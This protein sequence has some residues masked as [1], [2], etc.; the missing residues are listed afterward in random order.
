MPSVAVQVPTN[1]DLDSEQVGLRI[2][3]YSGETDY[4]APDIFLHGRDYYCPMPDSPRIS[5][6]ADQS[7]FVRT[8]RLFADN[9][10]YSGG[11]W[12][13]RKAFVS[14]ERLKLFCISLI[15]YPYIKTVSSKKE[16]Y[17]HLPEPFYGGS[18]T[19]GNAWTFTDNR[20]GSDITRYEMR[21]TKI[22]NIHG[23]GPHGQNPTQTGNTWN[24]VTQ[25][26]IWTPGADSSFFLPDEAYSQYDIT[27]LFERL[28]YLVCKRSDAAYQGEF[29]RFLL[30]Q[31]EPLG[32]ALQIRGGAQWDTA[33]GYGQPGGGDQVTGV[34]ST[35]EGAPRLI[36]ENMI[37]WKW[38]DVPLAAYN[39]ESW[40]TTTWKGIKSAF[41]KIN[42][43]DFGSYTLSPFM[44]FGKETLLLRT[45]GRMQKPSIIGTPLWDVT[46]YFQHSPASDGYG[47]WNRLLNNK[48]FFQRYKTANAGSPNWYFSETFTKLFQSKD[49]W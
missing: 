16:L 4:S 38:L 27:V 5:A 6:A 45:A 12:V 13:S 34:F 29:S 43:N 49:Y 37:T 33:A 44:L 8:Y 24:P 7:Q 46:F 36:G 41:G 10:P 2:N 28:P 39:W 35:K 47:F 1:A 22:L 25:S 20:T 30:P 48:G 18:G 15:G 26:S 14:S 19:D 31:E 17:R 23:I 42:D 11:N 40:V 3:L 21:A 9:N 32:R